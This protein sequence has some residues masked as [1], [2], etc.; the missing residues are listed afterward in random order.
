MAAPPRRP[1]LCGAGMRRQAGCGTAGAAATCA[2]FLAR[3]VW[4]VRRVAKLPPWLSHTP[5]FFT[6]HTSPPPAV[7]AAAD[8][9]PVQHR[10]LGAPGRGMAL[11]RQAL[12]A[13]GTTGHAADSGGWLALRQYGTGVI[14]FSRRLG[15]QPLGGGHRSGHG[16]G[17]AEAAC[18]AAPAEG[19]GERAV[20]WLPLR[21]A[22][23]GAPAAW[24][25]ACAWR[26]R[27]LVTGHRSLPRTGRLSAATAAAAVSP[28]VHSTA[29]LH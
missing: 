12:S 15:R 16:D 23:L 7:H 1:Q 26:V 22:V 2:Q 18:L 21:A 29:Q 19:S 3:L 9:A 8:V 10:R 27:G 14:G 4:Q 11:P 13:T 5:A 20:T 25:A 24:P 28:A 17:G 6:T